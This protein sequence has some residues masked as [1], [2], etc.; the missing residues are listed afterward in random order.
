[1]ILL[2]S[3]YIGLCEPKIHMS[4]EPL[5]YEQLLHSS[6]SRSLGVMLEG[7]LLSVP[8]G[9][10]GPWENFSSTTRS[11][12]YDSSRGLKKYVFQR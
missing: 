12:G 5:V 1:V 9:I 2:T 10:C 7:T 11:Q 8:A 4:E 6:A 3:C